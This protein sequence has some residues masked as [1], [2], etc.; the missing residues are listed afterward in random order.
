MKKTV[1]VEREMKRYRLTEAVT[2][3]GGFSHK[4]TTQSVETILEIRDGDPVP[5]GA[6]LIA[7]VATTERL[8]GAPDAA[9]SAVTGSPEREETK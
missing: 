1:P 2:V 8:S 3:S 9:K 5:K 7:D 4:K 6:T